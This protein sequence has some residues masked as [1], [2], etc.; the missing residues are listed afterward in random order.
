MGFKRVGLPTPILV[1]FLREGVQGEFRV[2]VWFKGFNPG[3][4]NTPHHSPL[5][6]KAP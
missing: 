6:P 2:Y 3:F 5:F 1:G 4:P